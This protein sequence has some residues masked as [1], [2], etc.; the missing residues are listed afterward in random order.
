LQEIKLQELRG[1]VAG[2]VWI[3]YEQR[4]GFDR[5]GFPSNIEDVAW[6]FSVRL[7]YA[8]A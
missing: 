8:S 6:E 5:Q 2:A 7:P 3:D 1:A 4:T